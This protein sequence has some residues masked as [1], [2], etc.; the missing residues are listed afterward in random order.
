MRGTARR[1]A[2]KKRALN[3]L[4]YNVDLQTQR[5]LYIFH[6]RNL[7]VIVWQFAHYGGAKRRDATV[8][9][10]IPLGLTRNRFPYPQVR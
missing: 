8:D 3:L 10:R 5:T 6:L 2:A 4:Y 1:K 9:A 7:H